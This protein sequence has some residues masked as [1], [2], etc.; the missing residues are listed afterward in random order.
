EFDWEAEVTAPMLFV[1]GIPEENLDSLNTGEPRKG[2]DVIYRQGRWDELPKKWHGTLSRL[3][4]GAARVVWLRIGG[5]R[6]KDA[7]KFPHSE[8]VAF[9]NRHPN[10]ESLVRATH[11]ADKGPEENDRL[12]STLV[13]PAYVAGVAYLGACRHLDR[14]VYLSTTGPVALRKEWLEEAKDFVETLADKLDQQKGSPILAL[15]SILKANL[16]SEKR[17]TRDAILN[18]LILTYKAWADKQSVTTKDLRP[19]RGEIPR[20]GG[21]DSED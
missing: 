6:V 19:A 4:A 21:L 12:I 11:T 14:Q 5:Q 3:L 2:Y 17:M 16:R 8:L 20:L 18:T 13:S 9:L 10:L 7:P 1:T 15:D